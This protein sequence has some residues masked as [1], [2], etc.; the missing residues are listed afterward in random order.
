MADGARVPVTLLTGFL[1]AGKTARLNATLRSAVG[2][3]AVIENELGALGVDGALVANGHGDGVIE[4]PNGCL[5][6]SQEVDLVGALE[7]LVR[8]HRLRRL[9]RIVVE[10]TGLADV[11]PVISLLRDATDPLAEVPEMHRGLAGFMPRTSIWTARSRWHG[12]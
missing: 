6:C 3:V 9:E 12:A 7:A 10:T 1:G 2:R 4:L 11:A 8:R 5:C